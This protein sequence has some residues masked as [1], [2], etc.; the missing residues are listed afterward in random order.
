MRT[1]DRVLVVKVEDGCYPSGG[2]DRYDGEFGV[3]QHHGYDSGYYVPYILMADGVTIKPWE[4]ELI[5][6]RELFE[7]RAKWTAMVSDINQKLQ[8]FNDAEKELD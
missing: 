1:G 3:Y 7:E 6:P 2:A 5:C 4:K 8:R